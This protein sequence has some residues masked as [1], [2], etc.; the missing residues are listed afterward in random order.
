M[1]IYV[2]DYHN[3]LDYGQS[4]LNQPVQRDYM[5]GFEHCSDVVNWFNLALH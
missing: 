2:G 4:I 1:L 3:P 5:A